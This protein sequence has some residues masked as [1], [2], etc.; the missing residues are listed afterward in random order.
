[1][2]LGGCLCSPLNISGLGVC[3]CAG[4]SCDNDSWASAI[5]GLH[6]GCSPSRIARITGRSQDCW[7]APAERFLCGWACFPVLV[8]AKANPPRCIMTNSHLAGMC[9]GGESCAL[10][11]RSPEPS[12]GSRQAWEAVAMRSQGHAGREEGTVRASQHRAEM[13]YPALRMLL[14]P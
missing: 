9:C 5:P 7:A 8:Q 13:L 11:L 4:T 10:T 2:E 12:P 14:P 6:D 1:M 3:S